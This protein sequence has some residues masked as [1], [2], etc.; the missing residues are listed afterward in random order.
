MSAEIDYSSPIRFLTSLSDICGLMIP[1]KIEAGDE[2][3]RFIRAA[4][5][6][7]LKRDLKMFD[8][9]GNEVEVKTVE[10]IEVFTFYETWATLLINGKYKVHSGYFAEMQEAGFAKER[11]GK[12]EDI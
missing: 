8:Q 10:C 9:E 2:V 12:D 7:P 5:D 4:F 11:W 6:L 3:G 1:E